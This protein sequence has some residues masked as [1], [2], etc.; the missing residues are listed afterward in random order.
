MLLQA[1]GMLYGPAG[2]A[3]RFSAPFWYLLA[4]VQ[5]QSQSAQFQAYFFKKVQR[6]RRSQHQQTDHGPPTHETGYYM[7]GTPTHPPMNAAPGYWVGQTTHLENL[8]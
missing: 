8:A 4:I 6:A 5:S 7:G 3:G 2:V 1:K